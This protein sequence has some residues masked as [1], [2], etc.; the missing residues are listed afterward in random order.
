MSSTLSQSGQAN[1]KVLNYNEFDFQQSTIIRPPTLNFDNGKAQNIRHTSFII[2]SRDRDVVNY[3]NPSEYV[4]N[5]DEDLQ[6]VTAVELVNAQIPF[7]SYIVNTGNNVLTLMIG[8]STRDVILEPGD[9]QP[10]V[11][12]QTLQNLMTDVFADLNVTFFVAY[13][14]T[15]DKFTFYASL[16]FKVIA[17]SD[18]LRNTY[19]PLTL[20]KVLGFDRKVHESVLDAPPLYVTEPY[21]IVA[22]FRKNFNDTNYVVLNIENFTVNTSI[23]T[24]VN[25]SFS[26]I[27][28]DKDT[29][30][31][32][33][34]NTSRKDFN[35]PISRLSKIRIRFTYADG[36]PF[37]F[38]NH[39][40]LIQLSFESFKQ[41]RKYNSY[42]DN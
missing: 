20:A 17:E 40:H 8:A 39:D 3:P 13:N 1:N 34:F 21:K 32:Y 28:G 6:D 10:L 37:D 22:P 2:D 42:I 27:P 35:P 30:N 15:T 4:I 36:R 9:Y 12:A 14:A 41:V 29:Q 38:Q 16:P 19:R 5:L 26:I 33:N 11:M 18:N 25:K 31:F 24:M 7:K 23:N